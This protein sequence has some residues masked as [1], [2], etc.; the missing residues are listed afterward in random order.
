MTWRVCS[1]PWPGPA[2]PGELAGEA[3]VRAAFSRAASPAGISAR[4]RG[5]AV[6]ARRFRGPARSRA[7]LATALVVAVAGLGSVFAAY[8]DV[9]PSPIQQLAHVTVAAPAPPSS[10]PLRSVT[11][12]RS[13]ATH[14]AVRHSGQ[15]APG[16]HHSTSPARVSGQPTPTPHLKPGPTR[17]RRSPGHRAVLRP[18]PGALAGSAAE[19]VGAAEPALVVPGRALH[20]HPD[21]ADG[22]AHAEPLRSLRDSAEPLTDD[23]VRDVSGRRTGAPC[24]CPDR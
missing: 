15:P 6:A 2:E 1:P 13:S 9:L 8:I 11:A 22:P 14:P 5:G 7:R 23:P 4:C 10:S 19:G 3:A 12:R 24:Q 21:R 17:S 16:P 20:R 18:G